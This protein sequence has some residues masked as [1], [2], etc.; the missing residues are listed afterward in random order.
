M[1]MSDVHCV[2]VLKGKGKMQEFN[3]SLFDMNTRAFC[4]TEKHT[5]TR[6]RSSDI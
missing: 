6:T 1:K 4:L 3:L 5:Y 2:F